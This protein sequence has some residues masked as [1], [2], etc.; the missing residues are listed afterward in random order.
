M[1]HNYTDQLVRSVKLC[2]FS[3]TLYYTYI[4]IL[5]TIYI[6]MVFN[7][8]HRKW[9]MDGG[10]ATSSLCA[11]R[12]IIYP[13]IYIVDGRGS[14]PNVFAINRFCF[15][16]KAVIRR[17]CLVQ[18]CDVIGVWAFRIFEYI[19]VR[20]SHCVCASCI[21]WYADLGHKFGAFWN[22]REIWQVGVW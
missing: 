9:T 16:A 18:K 1:C 10:C 17:F 19:R 13:Y 7:S 15:H 12:S 3:Y 5:G 20:V 14:D 6:H 8:I 21:K 22:V 11:C 2:I 4:Y